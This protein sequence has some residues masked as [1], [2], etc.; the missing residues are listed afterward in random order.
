MLRHLAG[1]QLP[2]VVTG[3]AFMA[4]P[5]H[6]YIMTQLVPGAKTAAQLARE[7]HLQAELSYQE[8]GRRLRLFQQLLTGIQALHGAGVVLGDCS[9]N[10]SSSS[11]SRAE[12][13]T[14]IDFGSAVLIYL[15]IV[16]SAQL[17][18]PV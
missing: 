3:V 6:L 12:Q 16:T 15:F 9:G 4:D 17:T 11:S 7:R 18:K 10:S 13:V 5:S 14:I 2:H 1:Q 8:L